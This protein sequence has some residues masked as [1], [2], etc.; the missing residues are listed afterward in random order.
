MA[1]QFRFF[2][3][4]DFALLFALFWLFLAAITGFVYFMTAFVKKP[5]TAVYCGFIVFLVSGGYCWFELFVVTSCFIEQPLHLP[6]SLHRPT[7]SSPTAHPT[8][9]QAGWTFQGIVTYGLPYTP[10][11]YFENS[12][13]QVYHRI[14]FWL[15][16]F[17]PWNPLAKAILDMAAATNT[18]LHPGIRWSER[19]SYCLNMAEGE[20]PDGY[21]PLTRW[22]SL[23]CVFPIG[24]CF[25][26]MAVQFVA[27]TILAVW[28][29]NIVPNSLGVS[30]SPLFFLR[31]SFWW[32][33]PMEQGAALARLVAEG[34]AR[35][36]AEKTAIR[37]G[38]RSSVAGGPD[39]DEDVGAESFRIKRSL[40]QKVGG[41][42][43]VEESEWLGMSKS[44]SAAQAQHQAH[45]QHRL[46]KRRSSAGG[47]AAAAQRHWQHHSKDEHYPDYAVEVFGL[48]KVF[49][50]GLWTRYMPK[51]L[52]GK[53][54]AK[55]FWAIKDSWFG[56]EQGSL[57]CLLGPNGAGKTTTINC[58][59]GALPP[60]A[61][62][63]LVYGQSLCGEGGL[64]RVRSLMGVCPQF[65]VL[66]N[67]LS[68]TEHMTIYGHI[69][70]LKFSEVSQEQGLGGVRG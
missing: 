40:G 18:S 54:G 7:G 59:T 19:D 56:I 31:R 67:E 15:F 23:S 33:R 11:F 14:I 58:L 1:L 17:M 26:A 51:W 45:T 34:E 57:F 53:P 66:W 29:D 4:N 37:K 60:T 21:D 43:K 61:G 36:V 52:G 16:T 30:R 39:E 8:N 28:F 50:L 42:V 24:S 62:D 27:Y 49:P 20:Y 46:A 12:S 32:P 68:G 3:A 38:S 47:G 13:K 2:L 5:Q 70:G 9:T 48:Q 35:M 65:D 55:D 25:I 69:K 22:Q 6:I 63:A 44:Y 64:D 41:L 10:A